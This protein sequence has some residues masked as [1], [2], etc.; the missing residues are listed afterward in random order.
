MG[1]F[2]NHTEC[3]FRSKSSCKVCWW[4]GKLRTRKYILWWYWYLGF[5]TCTN[6][7]I[8]LFYPPTFRIIIAWNFSWDI[9]MSQEKSKT[10]PMQIFWGVKEVYYRIVQVGNEGISKNK[11]IE[12]Y[13]LLSVAPRLI[14]TRMNH[15]LRIFIWLSVASLV[16]YLCRKHI[17]VK[18]TIFSEA[19]LN[20]CLWW[21]LINTV[22][23]LA[24]VFVSWHVT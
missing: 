11:V 12:C 1:W 24:I 15:C 21:A 14:T 5:P 20:A 22:L 13:V 3:R 4:Y 2:W 18:L 19:H 10:M 23:L 16:R 17:Q 8:H 7:I 6:P 9:K